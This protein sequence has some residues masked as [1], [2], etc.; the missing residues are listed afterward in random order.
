LEEQE[1]SCETAYVAASELSNR[2]YLR[3]RQTAAARP[4]LAG[5]VELYRD[6]GFIGRGFLDYTGGGAVFELY[7]G[8]DDFVLLER[9]V[10]S[11]DKKAGTFSSRK[12]EFQVSILVQNLRN[13]TIEFS[14]KERIPVSELEQVTVEI[15]EPAKQPAPDEDGMLIFPVQVEAKGETKIQ[16]SYRML[17]DKNVIL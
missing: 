6:G 1:F 14:L 17:L 15:I 16:Y 13:E 4:I 2:V 7:W 10:E 12:K 5:P 9:N 3:S 8:S 11:S